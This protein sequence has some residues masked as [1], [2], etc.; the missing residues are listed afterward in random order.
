MQSLG[1]FLKQKMLARAVA[2]KTTKKCVLAAISK[3]THEIWKI[4]IANLV[5]KVLAVSYL[6]FFVFKQKSFPIEG[7]TR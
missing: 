7:A 5:P 3:Q 6:V 4:E 2:R 1:H